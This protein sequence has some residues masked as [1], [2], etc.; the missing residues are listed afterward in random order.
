[1]GKAMISLVFI[2]L[3]AFVAGQNFTG[4]VV[5]GQWTGRTVPTPV[6]ALDVTRQDTIFHS[7]QWDPLLQVLPPTP[8]NAGFPSF[9][10]YDATSRNYYITTIW[11]ETAASLWS[12]TVANEV[13]AVTQSGSQ[14]RYGFPIM[15][16]VLVG[17]EAWNRNGDVVVFAL[18]QNG[19][20]YTIDTTTGGSSFFINLCG[21]FY[22]LSTAIVL[23]GNTLY[24]IIQQDSTI[25]PNR[26]VVT[27]DLTAGTLTTV[28]IQP[29][30]DHDAGLETPFEMLYLANLDVLFVMY[31]GLFDQLIY[32]DPSTGA[33]TFAVDDM[34]QFDGTEGQLG[35]T[36][37]DFLADDDTWSNACIDT[38]QKKIYF[39]CSDMDEDDV[40]IT[41]CEI[42]IPEKEA[43]LSFINIAI[44]PMVYG[45][46][47]MQYVQVVA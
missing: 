28:A 41:L 43:I 36:S 17:L 26:Q 45:Y 8:M 31:T 42:P 39:Q 40:T 33:A 47:G 37:D 22:Q 19:S 44:E 12:M 24:A 29:L 14:V 30:K 9:T 25:N 13:S 32:T 23:E 20:V 5:V 38:V 34:S 11:N 6:W 16:S 4:Y 15:N 35:F 10:A 18:Y 21:R 7:H 46:V 3:V 27:L 1:M 2:A